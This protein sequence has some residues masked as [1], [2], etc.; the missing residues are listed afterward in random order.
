MC[1]FTQTYIYN[2]YLDVY[3]YFNETENVR[4]KVWVSREVGKLWEE[5]GEG[6]HSQNILYEKNILFQIIN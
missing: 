3:S 2:Y 5:L 4:V 1:V 6:K